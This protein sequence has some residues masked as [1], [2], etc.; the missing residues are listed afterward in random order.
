MN[1]KPGKKPAPQHFQFTR[2]VLESPVLGVLSRS[3]CICLFRIVLEHVRQWKN[4]TSR[5]T[6]TYK[7]FEEYGVCKH[8]I[9]LALRELEALGL[10]RITERGR[11][12]NAEYR[13]ASKFRLTIAPGGT[14]EFREFK[15]AEEAEAAARKARGKRERPPKKT[16]STPRNVGRSRPTKCGAETPHFRPTECGVGA[17][18]PRPT[19]CGVLYNI[20]PLLSERDERAEAGEA[21]EV[22]DFRLHTAK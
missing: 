2:A 4:D 18:N 7:Q 15:T 10:M 22:P 8:D 1:K 3:A 9:A 12:G 6:V 5:L 17:P 21:V 13:M 19:E 14:G 16:K 11:G 20:Y